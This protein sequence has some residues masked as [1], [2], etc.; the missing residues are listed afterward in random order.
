MAWTLHP[1]PL[2]TKS[3][4]VV[5]VSSPA[6]RFGHTLSCFIRAYRGPVTA[7]APA[8]APAPAQQ[9]VFCLLPDFPQNCPMSTA[10]RQIKEFPV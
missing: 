7:L 1:A 2:C 9:P 10:V 5:L 6:P 4:P 8:P 3:H